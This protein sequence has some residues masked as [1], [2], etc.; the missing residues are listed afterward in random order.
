MKAFWLSAMLGF[1][2]FFLPEDVATGR[3]GSR[4]GNKSNTVA[5]ISFATRKNNSLIIS[6]LCRHQRYVDVPFVIPLILHESVILASRGTCP[7][8]GCIYHPC[9]SS[10]ASKPGVRFGFRNSASIRCADVSSQSSFSFCGNL[11]VMVSHLAVK[12]VA[13][14]GNR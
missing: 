6:S 14:S 11:G 12:L 4:A 2:H 3:G 5:A 8:I 10:S 9:I 7:E 1:H 13:S